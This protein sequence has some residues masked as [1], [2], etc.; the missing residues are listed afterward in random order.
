MAIELISVHV[1][2]SGGSSFRRALELAYTPEG[3]FMDYSDR[4]LDPAS[5]MN[6][7]PTGFLERSLQKYRGDL[8]DKRVIHGHFW[9]KKYDLLTHKCPRIVFLRHPVDRFI[10]HYYFWLNQPRHGHTVHDYI[11]DYKLTLLQSARVPSLRYFY[12]QHFF[13]DVDMAFFDFVGFSETSDDDVRKLNR[14]IG[15]QFDVGRINTNTYEGYDAVRS[16]IAEDSATLNLL[17]DLLADD[18]RFY[19]SVRNRF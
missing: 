1:P 16:K 18:I 2:K 17:R 19:E 7:D 11:L 14:L 3:I 15:I 4:P 5:P 12:T 8:Q 9:I 6:V 10:S 13:R